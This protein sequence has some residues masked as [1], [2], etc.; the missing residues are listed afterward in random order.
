LQN[1]DKNGSD[2]NPFKK[3]SFYNTLN[4]I[5]TGEGKSITL[6]G[7]SI[8]LSLMGLNCYVVSYS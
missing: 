5:K 1:I 2:Y 4:E 8:L 3:N 7:T 6:A